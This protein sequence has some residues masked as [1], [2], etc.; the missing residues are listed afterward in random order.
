MKNQETGKKKEET[1]GEMEDN[2]GHNFV[3]LYYELV[4]KK[5]SG[6]GK[7]TGGNDKNKYSI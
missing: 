7:K 5:D 6:W 3:F 4:Q 1:Y 2:T